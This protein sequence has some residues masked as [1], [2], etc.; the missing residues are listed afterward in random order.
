[1]QNFST[2]QN[3]KNK[4]FSIAETIQ[5]LWSGYGKIV[6]LKNTSGESLIAKHI[7]PPTTN[8]HPRG[9]N[10]N[11][12]HQR[13]L[14]SYLVELHWY[15]NYAALCSEN[16][17]IPKLISAES[18]DNEHLIILEDLTASGFPKIKSKLNFSEVK[19]VL[20]WLANF[21]ATFFNHKGNGLWPIGTY[22]HL[23][24]RQDEWDAMQNGKL[25][26]FAAKIDETLNN[27]TYQTLVHGDAKVANFCF[28]NAGDKVAAV[29]FQYVGKGCGMKDVIYFLGSC[30]SDE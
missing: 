26:N 3:L 23:A 21:H 4:G 20:S 24:T 5:S 14:R 19:V 22:W 9:W 6:R 17:K 29:D 13:K 2:F 15:K 25:K 8:H 10:T 1:M 28:S 30:L 27:C 11:A 12:S 18:T 16:C 7:N